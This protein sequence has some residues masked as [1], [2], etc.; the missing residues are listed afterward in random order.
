MICWDQVTPI[1]WL[2]LVEKQVWGGE[3][4][5]LFERCWVWS[6]QL[7]RAIWIEDTFGRL[8][9]GCLRTQWWTSSPRASVRIEQR[10]QHLRSRLGKR[11]LI[12]HLQRGRSRVEELEEW[13]QAPGSS[14]HGVFQARILEWVAIS[15]SRASSWPRDGTPVSCVS[16]TGI[17]ILYQL[18]H[19]GSPNLI[20]WIFFFL[21]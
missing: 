2:R 6:W 5:V 10:W 18:S 19:L 3:W 15:F 14:V 11:F 9:S 20:T 7:R 16:Y 4:W 1:H 13:S 12:R 17:Q 8:G 21:N